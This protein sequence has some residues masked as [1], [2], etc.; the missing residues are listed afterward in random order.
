MQKSGDDK[1]NRN[2]WIRWAARIWS[3]PIILYALLLFIG[4]SWNW[5]TT[6]TADPYA[7][8]E[9][10][11][12]E[13][14]PPILMFLSA[15]ALLVAWRWE[16]VGSLAAL[17]LQAVTIAILLVDRPPTD[18]SSRSV[19]PY[20]LTLIVIVPGALFWVHWRRAGSS[21]SDPTNP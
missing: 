3:A 13:V 9:V 14:L 20:L 12:I 7:V 21:V 15:V 2:S 18:M 10:S 11:F 16:R 5:L 8:N 6:G 1:R 4:Y 17:G 19:L